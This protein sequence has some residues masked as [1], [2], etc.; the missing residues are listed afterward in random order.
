MFHGGVVLGALS[1]EQLAEAHVV[2]DGGDVQR[3]A[4]VVVRR[5]DQLLVVSLVQQQL[6]RF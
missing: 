3:A 1:D 4:V 2:G 6:H 5:V